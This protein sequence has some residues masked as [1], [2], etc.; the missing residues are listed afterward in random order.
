MKRTLTRLTT[1]CRSHRPRSGWVRRALKDKDTWKSASLALL[2]VSAVVTLVFV[3]PTLYRTKAEASAGRRA[4]EEVRR[5]NDAAECRG[6]FAGAVTDA[7]AGLDNATAALD[8]TR[9]NLDLTQAAQQ[10]AFVDL[11][12]AA[13]E[14]SDRSYLAARASIDDTARLVD[15]VQAQVLDARTAVKVRRSQLV[16]ASAVYQRLLSAPADQ[17]RSMCS[18]GPAG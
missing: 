3:V 10:Q 5:G 11:G 18:A 6:A 1:W 17:F 7:R 9:A 8:D 12:V 15:A 16:A 13:I 4:S 14:Q 2:A